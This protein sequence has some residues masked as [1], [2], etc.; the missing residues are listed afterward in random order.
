[1]VTKDVGKLLLYPSLHP[2]PCL[3]SALVVLPSLAAPGPESALLL[4]ENDNCGRTLIIYTDCSDCPQDRTWF[5]KLDG[6]HDLLETKA[7]TENRV[8]QEE[9]KYIAVKDSLAHTC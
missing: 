9:A 7:S 1:M 6:P 2:L 5:S 8:G 4:N 3:T